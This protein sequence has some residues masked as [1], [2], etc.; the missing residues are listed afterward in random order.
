MK[1]AGWVVFEFIFALLSHRAAVALP[2]SSEEVGEDQI[3]R[4]Y[5]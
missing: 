5:I 3:R 1:E 2:A 4:S